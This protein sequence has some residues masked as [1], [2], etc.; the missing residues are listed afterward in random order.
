M[1]FCFRLSPRETGKR[2][3]PSQH[4]IEIRPRRSFSRLFLEILPLQLLAYH[5]AVPRDGDVISRAN[6]ANP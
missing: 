6:L 4:V 5:I 3:I 2:A 1:A